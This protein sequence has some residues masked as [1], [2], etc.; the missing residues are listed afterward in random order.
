MWSY[1]EYAHGLHNGVEAL[2]DTFLYLDRVLIN[3]YP[4]LTVKATHLSKDSCFK[5][6]FSSR[7]NVASIRRCMASRLLGY[8]WP[9]NV[10][11]TISHLFSSY[12]IACQQSTASCWDFFMYK[13][14]KVKT[15]TDLQ[16][17]WTPYLELLTHGQVVRGQQN[18]AASH[19]SSENYHCFQVPS[20]F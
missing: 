12:P 13:K 3:T 16:K 10:P 5:Q 2:I 1:T 4:S 15:I 17:P 9:V 20:D 19:A 6:P 11:H 14:Y 18:K 7:Y 8:F